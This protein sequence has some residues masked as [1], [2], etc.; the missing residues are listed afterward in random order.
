[1]IAVHVRHYLTL[2]GMKYFEEWFANVKS[3]ISKQDGFLSI[4]CEELPEEEGYYIVL[5]F[6]DEASLDAWIAVDIHDDLVNALDP[7]RSRDYWE[8]AR[9]END[10]NSN[11]ETLEWEKKKPNSVSS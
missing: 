6:R 2:E 8:A 11:P 1:M 5:K 10:N 9:V 4:E 7:Y 3:H